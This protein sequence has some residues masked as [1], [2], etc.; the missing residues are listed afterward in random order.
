MKQM[1]Y[2]IYDY[3]VKKFVKLYHWLYNNRQQ[4]HFGAIF[5]LYLLLYN[6]PLF[7]EIFMNIDRYEN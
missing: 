6:F 1:R 3:W 2:F 5:S 7:S 4:E